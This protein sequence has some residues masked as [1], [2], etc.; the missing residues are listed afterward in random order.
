MV[1]ILLPAPQFLYLVSEVTSTH[2]TPLYLNTRPVPLR[3]YSAGPIKAILLTPR[4]LTLSP[5][6]LFDLD[7]FKNY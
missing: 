2:T 6:L 1:F 4:Y 5:D 7:T 3:Q